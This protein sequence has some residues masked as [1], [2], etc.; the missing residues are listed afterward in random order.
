[1]SGEQGF[2]RTEVPAEA[3]R[4]LQ[5]LNERGYE[6]YI[7]G[8]CVRDM[9][10]GRQPEDWDITTNALPAQVK[11]VFRRTVDTGIQHGT[12][13]VMMKGHGYEVTTYRIDG[14]Y[15][16][17]RHPDR[18]AFTPSLAEDLKRRDFTINAMAYNRTTG[19]VDLF[20]GRE[21]LKRGIIRCVGNP[22]E[23]FG[24][25]ALRILRAIRFSAQLGFSMETE[26]REAIRA[27]AP[28]I[29]RVSAERIRT[30]LE[31]LLVSDHPQMIRQVYETGLSAVFL[32]ELDEMM[33]TSQHCKHHCYRVGDH[34]IAAL[35]WTP[36]DRILRL[37]ALLHDV[38]KPAVK[39]TDERGWDHFYRHEQE[40]AAMAR[41]ILRRLK[42]DNDTTRKVCALVGSHDRRPAADQ[43][44][45]RR[46]MVDIGLEAFPRL[47]ALKRADVMAQGCYRRREKLR[48]IEDFERLYREILDQG[49]CLS[50]REL[51]V[52]GADL[53]AMGAKQG[54]MIGDVLRHLLDWVLEDPER[55]RR[56]LLLE[57][58]ARCLTNI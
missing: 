55:N 56:D 1:M 6:A 19:L 53:I 50:L 54:T 40:G 46:A 43:E 5:M 37:A 21:D 24:E 27:L 15:S 30:E 25:D 14:E 22:M 8:G 23:R 31:K 49:Q 26:T 29:G 11:S 58:A 18:V 7:V 44:S 51:K 57:E 39:T 12:V 17:G 36:A 2:M 4:I 52:G 33:T 35:E 16:D 45:V 10:L 20:A 9:I 34:T 38:A 32:P 41:G 3:E 48:G 47:F 13:T 28:S 42:F